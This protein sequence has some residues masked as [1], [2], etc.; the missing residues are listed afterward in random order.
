MYSPLEFEEMQRQ[1]KILLEM[2][3]LRPY[4]A[5]VRF[6]KQSRSTALSICIDRE[7]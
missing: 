4:G 6:V 2:A 1:V 5:P 7:V 3:Q